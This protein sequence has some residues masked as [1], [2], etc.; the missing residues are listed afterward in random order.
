MSVL[1]RNASLQRIGK[2]L[3]L[4]YNQCY[5]TRILIKK[6]VNMKKRLVLIAVLFTILTAISSA[7]ATTSVENPPSAPEPDALLVLFE[8][9][10][11]DMSDKEMQGLLSEFIENQNP[12]RQAG[13]IFS[14]VYHHPLG[15]FFQIPEGHQVLQDPLGATVQLVG[16]ANENGFATTIHVMVLGEP[17]ND[18]E[19]ITQ[20]K[21]DAFFGALFE[22][23]QFVSLD[24]YDYNNVTAHEFICLHGASEDDMM[25]QHSLC[26]SK[27]DKAYILTMTTLAE[28]ATLQHA[29]HAYDF[30]LA[31]FIAPDGTGDGDQGDG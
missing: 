6:E 28:E 10:T 1:P 5:K 19:S 14:G 26:F 24:H 11:S 27:G 30:F 21:V 9:I 16:P 17:Q 18:F 22:N 2:H 3:P 29:L 23:Y 13:E 7:H 8:Q 25:V 12:V 31:G 15:Y 4:C 20:S